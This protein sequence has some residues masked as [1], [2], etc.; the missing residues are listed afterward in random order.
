VVNRD[1]LFTVPFYASRTSS[2]CS[3]RGSNPHRRPAAASF[4]AAR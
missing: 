3:S 2:H 4:Y 1:K